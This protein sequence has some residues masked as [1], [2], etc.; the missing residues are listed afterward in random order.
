[1]VG[2]TFLLCFLLAGALAASDFEVKKKGACSWSPTK[3]AFPE[4][5][6]TFDKY[7]SLAAV[8]SV[9]WRDY[10][11]TGVNLCTRVQNQFMPSGCGSCWAFAT[12]GALSD[13]FIIANYRKTGKRSVDIT[14]APQVLLNCGMEVNE[15]SGDLVAG[16]CYGGS[17][18]LANV[19]MASNGITDDTC[20]PYAA[21]S[22]TQWAEVP[23]AQ[24][25]CKTCD[26]FGNCMLVEGQKYFVANHGILSSDTLGT[27]MVDAMMAEIAANGPIVCAMWAH[28]ESF[29][30]YKSGIIVDR[31]HYPGTT[32]DLVLVGYGTENGVPY[33][34]GRNSF[35]TVW[36]ESGWFRVERGTNTFNMEEY[37]TWA[38][39]R[40]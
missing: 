40:V 9:D 5:R 39:P 10:N 6:T 13:R 29:E 20:A 26:M 19:Y 37:C 36:G 2:K 38:T 16:S 23:C 24:T 22:P 8:D 17:A 18:H 25:M 7:T 3:T 31:T 12:T 21:M 32:H 28:S 35:G 15:T 27:R 1:M 14:L 4:H 33:W 34:I 30:K 11:G